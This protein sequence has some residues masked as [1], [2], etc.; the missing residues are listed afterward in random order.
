MIVGVWTITCIVLSALT[1]RF[2]PFGLTVF[3]LRPLSGLLLVL[4]II[5]RLVGNLIICVVLVFS[6]SALAALRTGGSRLVWI[7]DSLTVLGP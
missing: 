5:G 4:M 7:F 6:G 1:D 2:V 3:A